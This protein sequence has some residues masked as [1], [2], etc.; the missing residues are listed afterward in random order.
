M[1]K[2]LIGHGGHAREVM[3][4]MGESLPCF[5]ETEYLTSDTL[6]IS[7]FNPNEYEVLIAVGDSNL[8]KE[9]IK[10]LPVNTKY[11]SFIH[12]SALIYS[13]LNNSNGYFI[14]AYS[15]VTTD[16]RIGDHCLLNRSCHIGHDS[17]IGDYLSMM[18]GSII[19][20]NCTIG[21]NV[22]MG[23]NSS[24]R[25]KLKICDNVIIG[26]GSC[27]VKDINEPGTY[28]GIPSKKLNK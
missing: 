11:F 1:K 27:V 21:N 2:A 28:I 12:P 14:G 4:Q 7:S 5:V 13:N 3:A 10:K 20:G 25:E 23:T 26:A 17:V 22:Y 15:I 16:V 19:S 6:P 9:F 8:K 18:P 24:T